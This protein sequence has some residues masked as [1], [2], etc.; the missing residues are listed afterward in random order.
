MHAQLHAFSKSF[1]PC[2]DIVHI[3]PW[4]VYHTLLPSIHSGS[5]NFLNNRKMQSFYVMISIILDEQSIPGN[6]VVCGCTHRG[7]RCFKVGWVGIPS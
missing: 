1:Y 6:E 3:F 5:S 4:V 2:S 7:G